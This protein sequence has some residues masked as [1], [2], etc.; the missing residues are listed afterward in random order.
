MTEIIQANEAQVHELVPLFDQYRQFYRQASDP[1]AAGA[2]LQNR[3][4]HGEAV[5]FMAVTKEG[6]AVGFTLLYHGFSSVSM[7]PLLILNDLF[8]EESYRKKGIGEQ[9]LRAAQSY[10]RDKANKGLALET[11]VDNPAQRL[12]ERLGWQKDSHCFHYFWNAG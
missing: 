6:R 7:Q 2:Y 9:L 12:Y 8:V 5:I 10:C 1:R 4:K 3:M 11:A